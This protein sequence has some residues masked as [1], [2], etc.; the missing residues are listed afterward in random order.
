MIITLNNAFVFCKAQDAKDTVYFDENYSVCEK[1]VAAY[2]RVCTLNKNVKI[3]YKGNAT[4]YYIDGNIL[5]TGQYDSSGMKQGEF[6]FYRHNGN[7]KK[8]GSFSN[9]EMKGV[10]SYYDFRGNIRTKFDC[11]N[12]TDFTPLLLIKNNGDT[13]LNNGNG[14]YKFYAY[15]D[16]P[17]IFPANKN[18][19]ITGQVVNAKK[20]GTVTYATS[21]DNK[22]YLG[23][24]FYKNGILKRATDNGYPIT[25]GERLKPLGYLSLTDERLDRIEM[26]Y[27]SNM[28]FGL[29]SEG[30]EKLISWLLDKEV[31]EIKS[32]AK[33][34]NDNYGDIAT[35]VGTVLQKP[36][37][38]Y[39]LEQESYNV[40]YS[41]GYFVILS[42]YYDKN[43]NKGKI[44]I[45]NSDITISI[46]T[47]GYISN[48]IFNGNIDK[49]DI[50]IINFYLSHLSYL[51]PYEK[52][53]NKSEHDINLKLSTKADTS[54]DKFYYSCYIYNPEA[55]KA[56]DS[57]DA[58]GKP[59]IEAS[60]PGGPKGWQDYVIH[61]LNSQIPMNHGAPPGTYSIIVSFTVD[62][63]GSVI[64][65]SI[66]KDPGYGIGKEAM[67]I[68]KDGPKW[69]PAQ[70]NGVLV[71]SRKMQPIVFMVSRE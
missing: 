40:G 11:V 35:I 59:E 28:V 38:Q 6:S 4:D 62:K 41:K 33:S 48:T 65:V 29:G 56:R 15:T 63:D 57:T 32:K 1:E 30:E 14:N 34:F 53:G 2:Y 66:D 16:F 58:I 61:N 68:I 8:K 71:K 45:L 31:P 26:F 5:M 21:K 50:S 42:G 51:W 7:L 24:E 39:S 67:R 3:Y 36:L 69:I 46:D 20:E 49:K 70:Q 27:H 10:W 37:S 64:D 17:D 43:K 52:D 13:I 18:Y 23:T 54:S 47:T 19:F 60:F 55:A 12:A 44:P 25:G 22:N 9:N